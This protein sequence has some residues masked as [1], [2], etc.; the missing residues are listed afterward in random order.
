[1]SQRALALACRD[2]IRASARLEIGE[3]DVVPPP[4]KPPAV[5]GE[6]FVAIWENGFSNGDFDSRNDYHAINVTLTRRVPFSPYDRE[7]EEVIHRAVIGLEVL[8]DS[9]A[10]L[11][12][13]SYTVMN[14]ANVYL[15]SLLANASFYGFSEPLRFQ[16]GT[17]TEEKG[18]EWFHGDGTER[19]AGRSM[20]LYFGRAKRLQ[21]NALQA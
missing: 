1:M 13:N 16:N 21:S 7:A 9:I 3:C 8:G 2:V 14:Q 5:C 19:M 12:H 10:T 20:T 17:R 6:L 11:I 4:G 18:G 15:S